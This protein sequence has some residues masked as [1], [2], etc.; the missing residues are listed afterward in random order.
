MINIFE[1]N[2]GYQIT[3]SE[4]LTRNDGVLYLFVHPFFRENSASTIYINNR[5]HFLSANSVDKPIIFGQENDD[6]LELKSNLLKLNSK[7]KLDNILY[8]PTYPASPQPYHNFEGLNRYIPLINIINNLPI[9]YIYYCGKYI[10]IHNDYCLGTTYTVLLKNLP[11]IR[12]K[13]TDIVDKLERS[14]Y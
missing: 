3:L 8:Y 10:N 7:I 5:N 12:H 6:L 2:E 11:N 14:N 13:V 4:K 9:N 1:L